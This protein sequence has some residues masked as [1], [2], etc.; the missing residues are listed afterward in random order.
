MRGGEDAGIALGGAFARATLVDHHHLV[1]GALEIQGRCESDDS[2][3]D[4]DAAHALSLPL[5]FS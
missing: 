2:G 3:P 5:D 1:A 4:D